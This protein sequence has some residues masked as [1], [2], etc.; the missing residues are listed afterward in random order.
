MHISGTARLLRIFIGESDRAH[1]KALYD[2]IIAEAR[3]AGMAGVT[4]LQGRAGFGASSVVHTM[5]ILQL[6]QDL[7][8]VVEL[9]DSEENIA[10]FSP[11]LDALLEEARC[12][13]L[14]TSEKV[15][16]ERYMPGPPGK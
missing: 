13:A 9:V 12:G 14:V 6:S 4:V 5:K 15:E 16:I 3:H 10:A 7:P 11:R 2:A 8:I 1:G